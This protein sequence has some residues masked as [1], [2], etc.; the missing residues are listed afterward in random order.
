MD[1]HDTII[2]NRVK[3]HYDAVLDRY[4][5]YEVLGTFLYGSQNYELDYENSDIDTKAIILP[6]FDDFVLKQ[7]P[8]SKTSELEN[9]E[10]IDV[11]DIRLMF[12][13]IRK[14]NINFVEIL[15]SKYKYI[16]PK[17][18]QF[19]QPVLDN[20]E[21]IARYN[22]IAAVNCMCGMCLEKYEA[23]EHPYPKIIDKIE[24]YGYDP[25]QL[26]HIVRLEEFMRRYINGEKYADCLISQ[27]RKFILAIKRGKYT[28]DT[29]REIAVDYVERTKKLR[30]DFMEKNSSNPVCTFKECEKIMNTAIVTIMKYNFLTEFS[31]AIHQ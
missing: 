30:A 5:R 19:F 17:Y 11:K 21:A 6:R 13:C 4:P 9:G 27:Q 8:I 2:F 1:E 25:K 7:S 16:N 14:Q 26:S 28:L 24:K 3:E 12:E 10:Q 15:F 18:A 20:A 22:I 29:A 31:T 23:L